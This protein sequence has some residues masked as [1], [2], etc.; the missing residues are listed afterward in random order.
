V[1]GPDP[2]DRGTPGIGADRKV[3]RGELRRAL[4]E[5]EPWL[6]A[7]DVGP[8]SVDAGP[9]DACGEFPRL[10]PT[11]GPAGHA[12]LCRACALAAGSDAWCE[13]HAEEG[14]AARRWAAAL[15]DS[16][17]QTVVWWWYATGEL[18]SIDLPGDA[19]PAARHRPAGG[20]ALPFE[21]GQR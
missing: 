8:A 19:P 4:L 1:T 12:A 18:R 16:W 5:A 3:D 13:G 9:C 2:P 6:A 11:C 7:T 15:P 21:D 10:L 14:A 17:A 20:Q